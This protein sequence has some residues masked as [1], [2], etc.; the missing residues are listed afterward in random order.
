MTAKRIALQGI[1]SDD[2]TMIPLLCDGI[3][4]HRYCIYCGLREGAITATEPVE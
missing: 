1:T 4:A 3:P 2:G